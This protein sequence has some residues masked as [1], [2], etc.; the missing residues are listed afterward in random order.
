[1]LEVLSPRQSISCR[2]GNV[3]LLPTSPDRFLI[4]AVVSTANGRQRIIRQ[5]AGAA[6]YN[7]TEPDSGSLRPELIEFAI[8]L[9]FVVL[10]SLYS[11]HRRRDTS[12]FPYPYCCSATIFL[13][14][15]ASTILRSSS[16]STTN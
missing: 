9:S 10:H 1:M 6:K 5:D 14:V 2:V 7:S 11:S 15:L 8:I 3:F 16:L 13:F 4:T 12:S